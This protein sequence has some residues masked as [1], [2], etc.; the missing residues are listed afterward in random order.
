MGKVENMIDYASFVKE[1]RD[2]V[3]DML[4]DYTRHG[5]PPELSPVVEALQECYNKIDKVC[6][7][8]K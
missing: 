3:H 4:Y 7:G 5:C 1:A 8:K 6:K 2:R